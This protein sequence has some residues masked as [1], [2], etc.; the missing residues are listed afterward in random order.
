MLFWRSEIWSEDYDY[1]YVEV[2]ALQSALRRLGFYEGDIDGLAGPLTSKALRRFQ[3]SA[4]LRPS[5]LPDTATLFLLEHSSAATAGPG[6][7]DREG[8]SSQG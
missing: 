6:Q 5:G 1:R 3:S 7:Q 4:N 2:Q 8:S